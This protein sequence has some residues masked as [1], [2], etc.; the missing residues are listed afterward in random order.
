MI[1]ISKILV[2][3]DFSDDSR[4]A[5]DYGV[6]MAR[7]FGALLHLLHVVEMP[8]FAAY[9]GLSMSDLHPE[10]HAEQARI[11]MAEWAATVSGVAVTTEVV[12]GHPA[13][14]II[15][16]ANGQKVELIVIATHG[17]RGLSRLLMGSTTERVVRT[18]DCPVLT[19]RHPARTIIQPEKAH[20]DIV[21]A[22][23]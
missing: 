4:L 20:Q 7:Q 23:R 3:V 6:Q 22:A 17:R 13:D 21:V 8:V 19:I 16:Y 9:S 18:A 11:E 10:I 12:V 2:P 1:A 15:S 14:A 5:L